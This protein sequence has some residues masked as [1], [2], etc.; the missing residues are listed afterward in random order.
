[1]KAQA[2]ND[3]KKFYVEIQDRAVTVEHEARAVAH[4]VERALAEGKLT[5]IER[6]GNT[7]IIEDPENG[8]GLCV[9]TNANKEQ[10]LCRRR[11]WLAHGFPGRYTNN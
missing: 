7:Y 10:M 4:E 1:M 5:S 2:H 8:N 9:F 6:D 3:R 11:N